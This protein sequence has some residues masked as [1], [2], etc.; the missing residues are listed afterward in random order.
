MKDLKNKVVMV[1]GATSGIGKAC[2][3]AFADEGC[4]M[5]I[6]ARREKELEEVAELIRAKGRRVL[7]VP[8]DVSRE[9]QVKALSEKAFA[10]F[11]RVDIAMSNA[12]IALPSPTDK[13]EKKDW[14]KVMNVNFYGCVHVVRYFLPPMIERKEGHL[15]VN[16]SGWGL[17]GGAFNALYV[18]SKH[19]L[20]GY[21][22]TL[23]AEMAYHNIGVT[24]LAAGV[25]NTDIF[26]IAELKGIDEKAR[27]V[28]DYFKGMSTEKFAQLTINGVKKN[29]GLMVITSSAILPWYFKRVAP[30]TFEKFLGFSAKLSRRFLEEA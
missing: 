19:A 30:H 26:S 5:V 16:S 23:R 20:I 2:A 27:G 14:E 17:M 13:L 12:G 11:G 21:S 25:V 15:V 1:T 22:E 3:L 18:V 9:E 7:A 10:E 8:T 6:C 29:K 24:T 4:N 28:L